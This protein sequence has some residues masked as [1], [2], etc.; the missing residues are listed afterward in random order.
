M[1]RKER[2]FLEDTRDILVDYDGAKTVKQLKGLIDEAKGRI[3]AV[4]NE[5]IDIYGYEPGDEIP[6]QEIK[7]E[8]VMPLY[9]NFE[10]IDKLES[11]IFQAIVYI[12]NAANLLSWAN[13]VI[14][15]HED[16]PDEVKDFMKTMTGGLHDAVDM[17][18]EVP[19][20]KE[21]K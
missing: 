14:E 4:L 18:R 3:D 17:L 1:K 16:V 9:D 12:Q 8:D 6:T 10:R 13:T 11:P 15:D 7:V 21:E 5:T 20:Y 19:A 2:F